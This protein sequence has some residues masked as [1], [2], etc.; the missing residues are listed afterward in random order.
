M[1]HA[2][3][4]E[5]TGDRQLPG[6]RRAPPGTRFGA[7]ALALRTLSRMSASCSGGALSAPLSCCPSSL[8]TPAFL[9]NG[10]DSDARPEIGPGTDHMRPE[11][12]SALV[13]SA[14]PVRDR[15][16]DS[17][18]RGVHPEV[19]VPV[20]PGRDVAACPA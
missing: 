9:P 14:I 2:L 19:S 6:E 16:Q 20:A 13:R 1:E 10:T 15:Q 11:A 7:G 12:L 5:D 4:D 3:V 17:N 18:L 8:L